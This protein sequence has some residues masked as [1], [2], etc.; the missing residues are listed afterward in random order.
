M[1]EASTAPR[2]EI[3]Q[4]L[5]LVLDSEDKLQRLSTRLGQQKKDE[6]QKL[7]SDLTDLVL[8]DSAAE[9]SGDS[10]VARFKQSMDLFKALDDKE[11]AILSALGGLK[12]RL[13][14]A[15][16]HELVELVA[17]LEEKVQAKAK[18]CEDY[19]EL[20]DYLESLKAKKK[21][22]KKPKKAE[23]KAEA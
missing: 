16:E 1:T 15:E 17:A 6:E 21:P 3:V 9:L 7:Q 22:K 18:A 10:L 23:A 5:R 19:E 14:Q 13:K 8:N 4:R 12:Q 11:Q 2:P 20:N